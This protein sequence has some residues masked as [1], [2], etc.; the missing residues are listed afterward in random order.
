MQDVLRFW[1]ERGVDGFR[2]DAIDRLMKDPEL[3]DDPPSKELFGL[4]LQEHEAGRDLSHSRNWHEV[5][6]ALSAIR[7]AAGDA[8]LVGEVYLPAR[9]HA[10]YLEYLDRAFVFELLLAPWDPEVVRSALDAG[11]ST[12]TGV[13]GGRNA[14]A[15]WVLVESRLRASCFA[16]RARERT[17]RCDSAANAARHGVRLPGRRD[18]ARAR[19]GTRAAI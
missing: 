14:G 4:L 13:G 6:K 7:E 15:A 5:G 18:R 2:I 9:R 19:P 16:R 1:V 10:P 8:L 17:R 11:I 3:R 12:L